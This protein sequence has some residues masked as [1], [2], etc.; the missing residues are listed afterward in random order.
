[1]STKPTIPDL[2]DVDVEPQRLRRFLDALREIVQTREGRRGNALDRFATWRNLLDW[3][4]ITR[5]QGAVGG[6]IP[7]GGF[8]P[9]DGGPPDLTPPPNATG[10]VV[11]AGFSTLIVEWDEPHYTQGHGPAYV[12]VWAAQNSGTPPTFADANLVGKEISTIFAFPA[13]LNKT[14]HFWIKNVSRDGVAQ[15]TPTG[16]TN[17]VAGTTAQDVEL[18]L[19]TLTGAITES[20]LFN[21]LADRIN[22]IEPTAIALAV[23]SSTR[24]TETG[25]LYAQYT[26]KVDANGYIAGYGLAVTANNGPPT[27][28]FYIRA[29][30]FAVAPPTDFS[31]E[32][33]PVAWAI[34]DIW[35]Q[36]STRNVKAWNG[37]VWD[38]FT[39]PIPFI[40]QTTAT[41]ENGV[42]IPPGVYMDAAYI[43]NLTAV[44][45]RFQQLVADD[46]AAAEISAA[47]LTAGSLVVGAYIRSTS[48]APGSQGW[49]IRADGTAEF[50]GVVV[51]GA[52]YASSGLI[53][54][55]VITDSYVCSSNYAAGTQGW[56]LNNASGSIEANSG[57]IGGAIIDPDGIESDNYLAGVRGWR[58]DNDTGIIYA[59]D[60]DLSGA[61]EIIDTPNITRD[62]VTKVANAGGTSPS[63]ISTTMVIPAGE[64][65]DI[66][67]IATVTQA[68]TY[69]QGQLFGLQI[70]INGDTAYMEN[71]ADA[72]NTVGGYSAAPLTVQHFVNGIVGPA[73]V[74]ITAKSYEN[75]SFFGDARTKK[76]FV[77]GRMR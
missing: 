67:A 72:A 54:G 55:A 28:E 34:G 59:V 21:S 74:T 47:Q 57:L 37:T 35:Y 52:V 42:T 4:V 73:T 19:E 66:S 11:L 31:Q 25:E 46:I 56:K 75:N 10:L 16:G 20:E 2:P 12:E 62:S 48:Y 32:D 43:K 53:G 30:R 77:F 63:G 17:G 45:A 64:A 49:I 6:V 70:T 26:V 3:G 5:P 14:F 39:V 58:L 15:T 69:T 50:S 1:M 24:E 71:N 60:I 9:G 8:V 65:M 40:V 33:E 68:L 41:V 61:Q 23:E 76:L 44:Y 22:Q 36:P 7:G 51:R 29:D 13:G 18:L 38:P 27:S